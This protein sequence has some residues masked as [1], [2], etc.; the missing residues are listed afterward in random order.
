MGRGPVEK[1]LSDWDVP[2]VE[3]GGVESEMEEYDSFSSV[4]LGPE[5]WSNPR[6]FN[7]SANS[8]TNVLFFP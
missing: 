8:F 7:I 4:V 6:C 1:P 2:E 3:P 5:V